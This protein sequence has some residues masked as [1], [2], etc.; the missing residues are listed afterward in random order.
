[1]NMC[2]GGRFWESPPVVTFD[3][4]VSL[5]IIPKSILSIT[6]SLAEVSDF[7]KLILRFYLVLSEEEEHWGQNFFF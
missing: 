7:M 4:F 1:M 2:E 6:F 5:S 3:S